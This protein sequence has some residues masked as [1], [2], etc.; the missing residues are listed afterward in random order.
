MAS[1]E[2][3][4]DYLAFNTLLKNNHFPL[5]AAECHG[6]ITGVLCIT[7]DTNN[8]IAT[9]LDLSPNEEIPLTAHETIKTLITSL[10]ITTI[11]QL[12]DT[13]FG[14]YLLLP[15]D[16]TPLV[17]RSTAIS[18]WCQSFI[19][20]LGEAK[21]KFESDYAEE[22][23]EIIA[24][25]VAI[26]KVDTQIITESEEEEVAFT[27]LVE[28]VRVAAITIYTDLLLENKNTITTENSQHLH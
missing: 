11:E 6:L 28:Y 24:D 15:H 20:G 26:S 5:N 7:N 8:A 25:L 4:P 18:Q 13:E 1:I 3:L 12:A 9:L 16:D 10:C 2:N 14:F 22:L 21:V 23:Q 27:E 17:Q 19:S